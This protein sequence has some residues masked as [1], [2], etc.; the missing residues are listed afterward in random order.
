MF[1]AGTNRGLAHCSMKGTMRFP[2]P[3][4]DVHTTREPTIPVPNS[5]HDVF[6]VD[7]Q[8]GHPD[9]V[10]F[11]G[12]PG[13]LVFGD[14]RQKATKWK[15]LVFQDS[16]THIK[17]INEHQA[18]VAGLRNTLSVFDLRY[19]EES[20]FAKVHQSKFVRRVVENS[21]VRQLNPLVVMSEYKNGPYTKIGLDLDKESGTVA[22][23][24]DDGTVALYSVR[25]GRRLPS[26]DID[27]INASVPLQ[28][29]QFQ[30]FS[31]D[32]T[33]SL[34]VGHRGN[35]EVY[36]FGVDDKDDEA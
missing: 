34:F 16:I 33:A 4:G 20:M 15:K 1:M 13:H 8:P 6:A 23:A 22:A 32:H 31:G 21:L 12:R 27:K 14:M 28:A 26:R 9:V 2:A 7:F 10:L 29:L 5:L 3:W 36:S 25:S 35:I 18:L 30:T 19:A 11:G 24:H 17:T